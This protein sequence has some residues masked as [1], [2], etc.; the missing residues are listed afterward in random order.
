MQGVLDIAWCPQDATMLL[1]C[2]RDHR[3]VLWDV[4]TGEILNELPLGHGVAQDTWNDEVEWCPTTP[5]MFSTAS[6]SGGKVS[7]STVT[8]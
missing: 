1:S 3:T 5:G 7:A 6:A 2:A 4:T 8:T